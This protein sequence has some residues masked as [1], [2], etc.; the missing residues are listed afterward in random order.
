[1]TQGVSQAM[2]AALLKSPEDKF[3]KPNPSDY[4]Q[5]SRA[6]FAK[7]GKHEDLVTE[8]NLH[9]ADTNG[10]IQALDPR[11]GLP[12]GNVADAQDLV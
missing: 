8:K 3:A 2:L 4:T 10:G 5:A 12:V 9:F 1:M 7:T 6:L 11:T